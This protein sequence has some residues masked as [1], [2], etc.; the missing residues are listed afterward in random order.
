MRFRYKYNYTG[1]P[2]KP[3]KYIVHGTFNM[4]KLDYKADK[5]I[6]I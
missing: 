6:S 3:A 5:N 2:V 4:N 1:F